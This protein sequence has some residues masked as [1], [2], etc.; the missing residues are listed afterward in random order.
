M[1]MVGHQAVR[2]HGTAVPPSQVAQIGKISPV[3][4]LDAKAVVAIVAALDDVQ[5]DPLAGQPRVAGHERKNACTAPA[6]D[7]RRK[8]RP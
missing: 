1:D 7:R 5:R 8:L 6:V 4:A 2:M 3:I